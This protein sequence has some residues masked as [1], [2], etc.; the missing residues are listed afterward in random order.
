MIRS[1]RIISLAYLEKLVRIQEKKEEQQKF[2]NWITL[3]EISKK[4]I[5]QDDY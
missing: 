5:E 1:P 2:Y 4:I 3:K